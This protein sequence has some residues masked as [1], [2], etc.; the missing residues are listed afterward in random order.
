MREFL[1]QS[2]RFFLF[3][4]AAAFALRLFFILQFPVIHGDSWVYGELAKTWLLHGTLGFSTGLDAA[5]AS[6]I[7]LPGYP[8]FLAAIWAIFGLEHYR[9]VLLVQMF[10]DV[11]T[12][13]VVADLARR[14]VGP[15]AAKAAFAL[16]ALCPFTANY[17][18]CALA[19]TLAIFFTAL[20]F[21][22]AV[23]ALDDLP[24]GRLRLWIA[25]GAAVAAG[26]LVRPD[27]GMVL[28][29]IGGYLLW[30]LLRR[31][32][33]RQQTFWAGVLLASVTFAPLVP[34]TIR[35]WRDFHR[36]QPLVNEAATDPGETSPGGF[37]LWVKTWM[38]DYAS[39][40][41]V[42]FTVEEAPID[43][44]KLPSRA[45][46]TPQERERIR[47][48]LDAYNNSEGFN[49]TPEIDRGFGQI[50]AER[51]QRSPLRYYV[52]LPAL[53]VAD[54]WLRPRGEMLNIEDR[55]WEY[56]VDPFGFAQAVFLGLLN[57]FYL[58]AAAAGWA[59]KPRGR[60]W[61]MLLAFIVVRS[62]FL[63]TLA[64]PEPRYMLECYPVV[65]VFA[66]RGLA[67]LGR[68]RKRPTETQFESMQT[69]PPPAETAVRA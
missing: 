39:V 3:F 63:T 46:D 6:Y 49:F 11:G 19:E 26:L 38:L 30:R 40:V 50:A 13:F 60:Y 22:W 10:V 58:G 69:A 54:M 20:A 59:R 18:A 57:L 65:I 44:N 62:L 28:A 16:A 12:C 68:R 42:I 14:T 7:R 45:F 61:G 15:R 31:P 27:G 1:R 56:Q 55:W 37:A 9:A 34:W 53:R 43:I 29:I 67:G 33:E 5:H 4:T 24:S 32:R 41:D 36:F 66:A 47:Q 8:A 2:Q 25:C 51:I 35:N 17:T 23:A 64:N 21:D 52:W 48:L